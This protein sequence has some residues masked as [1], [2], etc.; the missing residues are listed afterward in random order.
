V[1]D[2]SKNMVGVVGVESSASGGWTIARVHALK[3]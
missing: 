1:I 3:N 2:D